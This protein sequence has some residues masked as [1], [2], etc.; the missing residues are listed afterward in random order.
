MNTLTAQWL[1][2]PGDE[3]FDPNYVMPHPAELKVYRTVTVDGAYGPMEIGY[4]GP[5]SRGEQIKAYH[6][7]MNKRITHHDA[8][9]TADAQEPVLSRSQQALLRQTGKV[10][11]DAES[12][13][14]HHWQQAQGGV[15]SRTQQ[16]VLDRASG[17]L[18]APEQSGQVL[19]RAQQALNA[20]TVK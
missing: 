1:L 20:R 15:L 8:I 19:G 7:N 2:N 14:Q 3:G 4:H 10:T 17:K 12:A 5:E 16:N 9:T 13:L 6:M 18:K 11:V